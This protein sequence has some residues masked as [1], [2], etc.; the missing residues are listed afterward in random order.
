MRIR[1]GSPAADIGLYLGFCSGSSDP[2][3][4]TQ[5]KFKKMRAKLNKPKTRTVLVE[6]DAE[7]LQGLSDLEQLELPSA[8][9]MTARQLAEVSGVAYSTV[10]YW[11]KSGKLPAAEKIESRMQLWRVADIAKWAAKQGLTVSYSQ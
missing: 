11:A 8:E 3:Q 6:S 9:Y 7:P 10:L 5:Q 1:Q 2:Y 4:N